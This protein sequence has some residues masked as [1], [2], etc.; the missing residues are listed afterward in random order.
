MICRIYSVKVYG[1][2]GIPPRT[3]PVKLVKFEVKGRTRF[4]V[5]GQGNRKKS[6]GSELISI[7]DNG[8]RKKSSFTLKMAITSKPKEWDDQTKEC[9]NL[10]NAYV[11]A[12]AEINAQRLN[13]EKIKLYE[14]FCFR[15]RGKLESELLELGEREN[16]SNL[17]V[18]RK[19]KTKK[20][21]ICI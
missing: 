18:R 16:D 17:I 2:E 19:R 13:R 7:Y 11:L 3:N 4:P 5:I 6:N 12:Q 8:I 15:F 9:F 14:E 21:R 20:R 10:E 1:V